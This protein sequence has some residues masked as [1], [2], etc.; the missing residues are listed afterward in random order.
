MIEKAVYS[1]F[2][3]QME[4]GHERETYSCEAALSWPLCHY[5]GRCHSYATVRIFSR[6][7]LGSIAIVAIV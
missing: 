2:W 1:S 3:L 6:P 7:W 5:I 4:E